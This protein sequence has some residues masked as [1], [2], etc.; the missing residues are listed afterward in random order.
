MEPAWPEGN[1]VFTVRVLV[2]VT[3][4]VTSNIDVQTA[5]TSLTQI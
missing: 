4:P 2:A 3:V 1:T 5:L